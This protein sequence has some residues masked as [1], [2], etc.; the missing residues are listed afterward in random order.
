MVKRLKQLKKKKKPGT[1][2]T[3]TN[4][5]IA[6]FLNE[7]YDVDTFTA[8]SVRQKW[9]KIAGKAGK[10]NIEWTEKME[11]R[12]TELKEGKNGPKKQSYSDLEIAQMMKKEFKDT[13]FTEEII[14]SRLARIAKN[15]NKK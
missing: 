5:E 4:E 8:S 15:K 12:L 13:R 9:T 3:Y 14:K 2:K 6:E 11:K 7:E 1:K 10:K